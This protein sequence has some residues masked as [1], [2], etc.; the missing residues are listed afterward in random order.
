[1]EGLGIKGGLV[2]GVWR[3]VKYFKYSF[4][5]LVLTLSFDIPKMTTT[6]TDMRKQP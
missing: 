5:T 1:M 3:V 4:I 6:T 2:V